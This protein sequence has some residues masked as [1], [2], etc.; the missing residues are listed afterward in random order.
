MDDK[1]IYSVKLTNIAGDI[2]GKANLI[3]KR[4]FK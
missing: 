4:K 3:I 2:E 1:G